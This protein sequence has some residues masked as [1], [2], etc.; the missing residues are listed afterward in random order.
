[1]FSAVRSHAYKAAA[2]NFGAVPT[3]N[4]AAMKKHEE[5]I[6]IELK[7]LGFGTTGSPLWPTYCDK[8][9]IEAFK[10]ATFV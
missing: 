3:A 9:I 5:R 1:M 6:E 7:A 8:E 4:S 2:Q 10:Y